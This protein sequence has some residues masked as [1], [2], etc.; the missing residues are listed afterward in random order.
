M[1][2]KEKEQPEPDEKR[3]KG[4]AQSRKKGT[5]ARTEEQAT[6]QSEK[7]MEQ[8][9]ENNQRAAQEGEA[10]GKKTLYRVK[11]F[12]EWCKCCGICSAMCPVKIILVD[13][14]GHPYIDDQDGCIGCRNCEIHCPDFAITVSKRY[15]ERRKTN[16][17]S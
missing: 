14:Q 12:Y 8:S 17:I 6:T 1:E 10:K 16:G 5:K 3:K 11:F 4:S 9:A 7:L 2:K 13:E 15:P